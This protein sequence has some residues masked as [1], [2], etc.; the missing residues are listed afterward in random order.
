MLYLFILATMIKSAYTGK[1][2]YYFILEIKFEV[3]SVLTL[4]GE[5]TVRGIFLL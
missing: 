3:T 4:G 2:T 1:V 5:E